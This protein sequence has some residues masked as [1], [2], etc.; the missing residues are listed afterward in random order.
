MPQNS[1]DEILSR[2]AK[3]S[4]LYL[5]GHIQAEIARRLDCT[6]Q[7]VSLDLQ[8][9]RDEWRESIF[10]NFDEKQELELQ[11]I[12]Q[13]ERTYWAEYER[14]KLPKTRKTSKGRGTTE[15]AT[16]VEKTDMVE[17]RL[18]DP[19]YL[20]GVQWCVNKRCQILGL[21]AP[22]GN[23]DDKKREKPSWL[24]ITASVNIN[25]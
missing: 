15:K 14:S 18:G 6:Q 20:E 11:K 12:D 3:V 4:D 1:S 9:I 17:E 25:G 16:S 24:G 19:R 22:K 10:R 13:L 7:Q 23:S 8:V 5:K 21:D 2:R